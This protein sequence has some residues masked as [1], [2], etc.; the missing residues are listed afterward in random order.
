M[1]RPAG[2]NKLARD[3]IDRVLD[4]VIEHPELNEYKHMSILR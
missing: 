4:L 3:T 2:D 1:T